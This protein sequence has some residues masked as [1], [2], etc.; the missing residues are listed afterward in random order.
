MSRPLVSVVMSTFQRAHLLARSLVCYQR[1]DFD[2]DRFQLILID[3]HSKDNT[4][5]MVLDWAATTRINTIYLTQGPKPLEWTD[6]GY[7]LNAGI[8]ASSGEHILLTHPECMPGHKSVAACVDALIRYTGTF[9][10]Y[11]CCRPYYLT[12][13]D[14]LS[15]D[16]VDWMDKTP[17]VA[18][19]DIPGFYDE[20]QHLM[21][22][23]DYAPRCIEQIGQSG[24]RLQTWESWVFGGCSRETWRRL[25]GML[26]TK[27][28]G[29]VD[30]GFL[31][32]RQALGIPNHTCMG[33]DTICIHQNHSDPDLNVPTPRIEENWKRELAPL[34]TGKRPEELAYPAI[35]H[36]GWS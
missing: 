23:P 30:V 7:T 27:M 25:G 33:D 22:N 19:R 1:H 32:R 28:W 36:L 29:S 10:L 13:R 17:G 11:A 8:R 35:D 5:E 18:V 4:R 21:G 31:H 16:R 2:N 15:I 26:E 20:R 3:D 14:Q 9:G 6:C 12:A 24:F 34:V